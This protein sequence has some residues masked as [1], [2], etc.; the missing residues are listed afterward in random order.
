M[1]EFF[2]AIFYCAAGALL[3]R[4]YVDRRVVQIALRLG[5][6]VASGIAFFAVL[7]ILGLVK[8]ADSMALS[9]LLLLVLGGLVTGYVFTMTQQERAY[10]QITQLIQRLRERVRIRIR[11][12]FPIP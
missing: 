7:R 1:L 3:Y 10:D 4:V 12:P 11:F 2:L 5:L 9:E 6:G 8:P